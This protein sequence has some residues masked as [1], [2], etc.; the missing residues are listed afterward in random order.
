MKQLEFTTLRLFVAVAEAGTLSAGAEASNI[1]IAAV[2]KR[3]SDLEAATGTP[4]FQRHARGVTLTPA[5]RALLQHAREILYGVDRMH[6][7]LRQ[8]RLGIKG[9]VRVAAMNSAV[10]QFLPEELRRFAEDHPNITIDLSEWTNQGIIGALLEGRV[11][12]GVFLGPNTSPEITSFPYHSDRLCLVVPAEHELARFDRL[13]F[14]QT[15]DHDYIGLSPRSSI[16]QRMMSE[17]SGRLK[18][19]MSVLGSDALCRMVGA[20]LGIGIAPYLMVEHQP[21]LSGVKLVRLTDA[22]AERHLV[23]GLAANPDS[24]SPAVRSFVAHCQRCAAHRLG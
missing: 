15:L 17:S 24:I 19:R 2:S 7:E 3:I 18:L 6:A 22:W 23:V 5:G 8:F 9:H 13:G 10:V 1:A 21:A 4:F 20:G 16:A 11:D 12:V 14:A